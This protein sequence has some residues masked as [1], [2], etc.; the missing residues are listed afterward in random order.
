MTLFC[1]YSGKFRTF[2]CVSRFMESEDKALIRCAATFQ[3]VAFD[4]P[5]LVVPNALLGQQAFGEPKTQGT[6]DLIRTTKAL[7]D[8]V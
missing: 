2:L 3:N 1:F 7:P 6:S 4:T 5:T 8:M